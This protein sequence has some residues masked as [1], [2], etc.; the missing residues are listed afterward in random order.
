LSASVRWAISTPQGISLRQ[1]LGI[2]LAFYTKV[3]QLIFRYPASASKLLAGYP[4]V[5]AYID[6]RLHE[7]YVADPAEIKHVRGFD[8]CL[9]PRDLYASSY[10][11][12]GSSYE[13][14]TTLIFASLVRPGDVVFDIG[15]NIGWFTLLA[16]KMTGPRG[17]VVAFEPEPMNFSLLSKSIARNGFKNV[18]ALERCASDSDGDATLHLTTA[19]NMP[20]SHSTVRDFGQGSITVPASRIS[21]ICRDLGV[22]LIHL[23]KV[24]AEGA[25]P[26][27]IAGAMPLIEAS[28]VQ[29]IILEW[30]PEAWLNRGEILDKIFSMFDVSEIGPPMPSPLRRIERNRL[31]SER[32]NLYLGLRRDASAG[33]PA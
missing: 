33:I 16:A 10:I 24:D 8:I 30:N 14:T 3:L 12:K 7:E 9:N 32:P 20:G 26:Q 25:E 23:L 13:L 6:K 15:A 27:V 29:N 21:S 4:A 1:E 22:D 17:R 19:M 18:I 11:A 28:K 2:N 31:P 5:Q